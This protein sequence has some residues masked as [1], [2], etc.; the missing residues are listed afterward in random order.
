M[1]FDK[2]NQTISDKQR[3]DLRRRAEKT[4]KESMFSERNVE[5]RLASNKQQSRARWS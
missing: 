4:N 2:Q 1:A 5:R 3:E